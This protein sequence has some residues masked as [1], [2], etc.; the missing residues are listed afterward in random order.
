[1]APAT[2]ALHETLLRALKMAV[3]AYE[4]WL[5]KMS[6]SSGEGRQSRESHKITALS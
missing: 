6:N 4:T 5:K 2:R 1:M 3:S